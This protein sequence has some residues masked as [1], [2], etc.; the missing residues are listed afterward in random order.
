[1]KFPDLTPEEQTR[2]RKAA[3]A[4][5]AKGGSMRQFASDIGVSTPG[6]LKWLR[7]YEPDLHKMMTGDRLTATMPT[8]QVLVRLLL[9]K[10]VEGIRGGRPKLLR[11]LNRSNTW[12]INF[13]NTWAPDG[14]DAAIADLMPEDDNGETGLN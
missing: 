12:C 7:T 4:V 14:L 13:L 11:A 10:S 9:L 3:K 6:A 1:M 8:H 5:I 2:R